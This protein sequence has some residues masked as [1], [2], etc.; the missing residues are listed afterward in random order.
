MGPKRLGALA[1]ML[2]CAGGARADDKPWFARLF[3]PG[4]RPGVPQVDTRRA[5]AVTPRE[6]S[7]T[8]LRDSQKK[9]LARLEVL[10]RIK[11]IALKNKDDALMERAER[12]EEEASRLYEE[13][14]AGLPCSRDAAWVAGPS[15]M[16]G[17]TR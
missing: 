10:G 12:L 15:A 4:T 9:Y 5:P 2:T 14:T 8:R 16:K 3:G 1:L 6:A 13:Q 11:L 17:G 7:R